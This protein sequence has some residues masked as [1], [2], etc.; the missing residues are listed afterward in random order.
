MTSTILATFDNVDDALDAI[1]E[2][3]ESGYNR[4]DLGLALYDPKNQYAAYIDNDVTGEEGA[5]FGAVM[6]GLFGAVVGLAAITVPGIGPVIAAGPLAAAAGALAGAGIG[7]ASGAVTGGITGSLVKLGIPQEDTDYYAESLRQGAALLTVT[8]HE[9][10]SD[11]AIHIVRKYH[12]IDVDRRV[13][14][15]RARGW[16]GFDPMTEPFTARQLAELEEKRHESV[17]NRESDEEAYKR[18]IRNYE[19][20]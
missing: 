14:Q 7:A 15:W 19:Q 11:R 20:W 13:A 18:A 9:F 10:D 3:S 12:P 5:S 17:I 2:L 8:A 4:S 16:E 6:G 1:S